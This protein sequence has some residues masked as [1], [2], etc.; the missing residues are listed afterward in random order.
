MK[1]DKILGGLLGLCVGDAL[2]VPV[3]F[4]SRE[5]LRKNPV[6]DMIGYGTY[7]QPPGTWS[8]DSSLTFCLA[9]S[10]CN[11]FDLRDIADKFVKWMY[12]GYWT[13]WGKAFDVGRTTQIAIS[14]L[15]QGVDPLEAGPKDERSNGNGSLM[16]I[17]PLIFY[18]EKMDKEKQF[19]ITHQVSRITH[20]HPR[21]QMACGI[22]VQFGIHLFNGDTPEAAYEEMKDAVLK[23]YS[24]EPY[25]DELRYF[26][27]ILASDI[28]R[29]PIDS[30]K[31]SGYVV[32]SLEACLWCFLNNDSYRD[33][34]ITAVNLGGDTDTIGALAGGLAGIYYGYESI[35]KE[36]IRRIAKADEI[37]KLGERLYEAIYGIS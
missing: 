13:P 15:K 24:K 19:E 35:P 7:N 3:E 2:G 36:W 26:S 11:G 27:R 18:V 21:S 10:L 9:E 34:V 28:S 1:K 25:I 5:E 22:C 31:S 30:I 8:D 23:Y 16:R 29:L 4:Q 32:D 17:L 14:R 37:I 6:K 33:T 12:E 20:G